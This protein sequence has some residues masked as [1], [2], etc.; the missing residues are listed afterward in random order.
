M[1]A[2]LLILAAILIKSVPLNFNFGTFSETEEYFALYH[3]L[4]F[5]SFDLIPVLLSGKTN[6]DKPSDSVKLNSKNIK[7]SELLTKIEQIKC[8]LD[9]AFSPPDQ[10]EMNISALKNYI[11]GWSMVQWS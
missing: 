9:P 2:T 1:Y 11:T 3:P 6:K 10:P 4:R 8:Q 5:I 7:K